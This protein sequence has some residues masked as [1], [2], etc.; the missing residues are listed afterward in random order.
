MNGIKT[1]RIREKSSDDV[2][3]IKRL[4][5]DGMKNDISLTLASTWLTS[6]G[7]KQLKMGMTALILRND[8]DKSEWLALKLVK[9]DS[10]DMPQKFSEKK[11][12]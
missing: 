2:E 12:S 7:K 1:D 9:C 4:M 3:I 11:V 5:N 6:V 10:W 8:R